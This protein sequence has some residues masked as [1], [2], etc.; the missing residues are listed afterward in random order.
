M[1]EEQLLHPLIIAIAYFIAAYLKFKQRMVEEVFSY[2]C[3]SAW[4]VMVFLFQEMS[5]STI[6]VMGR[7]IVFQIPLVQIFFH[8]TLTHYRKRYKDAMRAGGLDVDA[9]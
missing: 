5:T 6:R 3:V 2:L 9:N 7:Y 4:F 1:S 8:V